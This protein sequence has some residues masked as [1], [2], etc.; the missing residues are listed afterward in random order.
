M[1]VEVVGKRSQDLAEG[2]AA[3]Q[4]AQDAGP[5]LE[6]QPH[7]LPAALGKTLGC[8]APQFPSS[9]KWRKDRAYLRKLFWP[10]SELTI[11]R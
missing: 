9:I 7:H 1:Q 10:F 5:G 2:P 3:R 8:F 4:S 6:A 11:E